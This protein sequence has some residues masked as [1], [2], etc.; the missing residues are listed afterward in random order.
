MQFQSGNVKLWERHAEGV[1]RKGEVG[2]MGKGEEGVLVVDT[3]VPAGFLLQQKTNGGAGA[4]G[5]L[6]GRVR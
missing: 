5:D 3:G 2:L 4:R 1:G 6:D